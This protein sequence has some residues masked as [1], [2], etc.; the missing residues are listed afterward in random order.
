M[1]ADGETTRAGREKLRMDTPAAFSVPDRYSTTKAG[2]PKLELD[3]SEAAVSAGADESVLVLDDAAWERVIVATGGAAAPCFQCGVCTAICPWGLVRPEP[4]V[5]RRL[6]R[7]AQ[8]GAPGWEEALWL[9]TS[10][11]Q[12]A[13][14]CPRGVDVPGVIRSLRALAWREGKAPAGLPTLLWN[15]Y[16]DGNPYG[17]PPSQRTAWMKDAPLPTFAPDQDILLYI[18]CAGN[19]D[20]RI[21]KVV[22]AVV[23]ALRAADVAFGVLGDDEPCCGEAARSVGQVA[24]ADALAAEGSRLFRERGVRTV[25]TISPHCLEQFVR[26]YDMPEGFRAVHYTAYLR[27]LLEAGRLKLA[28]AVAERVTF[29]DPCYLGRGLGDYESPRHV[30]MSVPGVELVEMAHSREDSICCG[31]GGGR[32]W[33][34]TPASQRFAALR[35]QEAVAAG[36]EVLA[37]A[38]PNCI[39]CIE[40]ALPPGG[41]LRVADVAELVAQSLTA[42]ELAARER[43]T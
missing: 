33:M 24:F 2:R 15:I 5:I 17:R 29:Q 43:T 28:G 22:R 6:L 8:L 4:V 11:R 3:I 31:G 14:Q 19:Y 37:T 21:Q 23:T 35:V 20:R 18:G 25:V 39:S 16:W 38:C 13:L 34:E 40:D 9:C 26:H 42:S 36:A 41:G 7:E 10:C 1:T 12:C 30:L 27:E 32:M